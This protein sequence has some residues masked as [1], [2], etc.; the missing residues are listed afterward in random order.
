MSSLPEFF[1]AQLVL[2]TSSKLTGR[3]YG[4]HSVI[5]AIATLLL[6]ALR[7]STV[8]VHSKEDGTAIQGTTGSSDA[9][10]GRW[11]LGEGARFSSSL[12]RSP[13]FCRSLRRSRTSWK[14]TVT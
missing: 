6:R 1:D 14:S 11:H 2:A 5:L 3:H 12:R 4:L 10:G 7:P 8:T 9:G 13:R